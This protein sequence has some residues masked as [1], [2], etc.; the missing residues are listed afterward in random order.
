MLEYIREP[1]PSATGAALPPA[2]DEQGRMHFVS[3]WIPSSTKDTDANQTKNCQNLA[4]LLLQN[5]LARTI[6][7][8]ADDERATVRLVSTLGLS[9]LVQRE[10]RHFYS[11]SPSLAFLAWQR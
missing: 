7:H 5:G 4:E 8:R 1:L 10:R 9:G 11:F 6:P 2:S 3:L